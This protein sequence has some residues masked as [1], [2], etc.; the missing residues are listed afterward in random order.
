MYRKT[1]INDVILIKKLIFTKF[2]LNKKFTKI[3][4]KQFMNNFYRQEI[5]KQ[6]YEIKT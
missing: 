6:K 2:K 3:Y 5:T 4:K 1:K